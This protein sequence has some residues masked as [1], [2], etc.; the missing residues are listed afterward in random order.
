MCPHGDESNENQ[1][2]SRRAATYPSPGRKPWV[3][4]VNERVPE[5]RQNS[6]PS[7]LGRNFLANLSYFHVGQQSPWSQSEQNMINRVIRAPLEK[8]PPFS[9]LVPEA[10]KVMHQLAYLRRQTL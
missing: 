6:Q 10:T 3:S 2:Y 7:Y 8:T 5:G 9:S 1:H 4:L